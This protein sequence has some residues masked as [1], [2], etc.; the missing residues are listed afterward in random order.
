[1]VL[2]KRCGL[3]QTHKALKRRAKKGDVRAEFQG[4]VLVVY[5]LPK[6]ALSCKVG[7]TSQVRRRRRRR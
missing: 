1:M 4:V 3:R 7:R 5:A 2:G 6:E